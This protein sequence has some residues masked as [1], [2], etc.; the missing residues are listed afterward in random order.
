LQLVRKAGFE[1]GPANVSYPY[2]WWSRA[3]DFG[4][5]ERW[6]IRKPPPVGQREG[7]L[8]N[9]VARKPD[10]SVG[11]WA[12]IIAARMT[13]RP[14]PR[15]AAITIPI[16]RMALAARASSLAASARCRRR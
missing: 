2:L 8:V 15:F 12:P 16:C 4:L 9:L 6:H 10:Q 13:I 3:K 14:S 11:T 7:T 5:L 1:F